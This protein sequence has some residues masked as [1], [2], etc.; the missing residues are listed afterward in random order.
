M[1]K[2]TSTTNHIGR[3]QFVNRLV[4]AWAIT[5]GLACS[6]QPPS[7]D[8]VREAE[9][10]IVNG[11][12]E[13]GWPGVGALV[14]SHT[15]DGYGSK[16]IFCTGT[17]IHPQWVLTAAHCLREPGF[18][19]PP[20]IIHFYVGQ[21]ART[22][23]V[24]LPAQ[25]EVLSVDAIFAHPAYASDEDADIALAHLA[26]PAA[27]VSYYSLNL[28]ST[29]VESGHP[30]LLY[31]GFGVDDGVAVTGQGIKRSTSMT[32]DWF[33]A[34]RYYSLYLGS[35]TCYGD[36][37]GPGLYGEEANGVIVGV[38]S[39]HYSNGGVDCQDGYVARTRVDTYHPWIEATL[40]QPIPSCSSDPSMCSCSAGCQ[41]DGTCDSTACA[42]LLCGEVLSCGAGCAAAPN[43]LVACYANGTPQARVLYQELFECGQVSCDGLGGAAWNAC[44]SSACSLELAACEADE[45][46][47]PPPDAG[48]PDA[49]SSPPD[50]A[51]A[52]DPDADHETPE[53][54]NDTHG[55]STGGGSSAPI[56]WLTMLGAW[57]TLLRRRGRNPAAQSTGS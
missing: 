19:P 20:Y 26:Q 7:D 1:K 40:A 52:T 11:S 57:V 14:F 43:C 24:G 44:I 4:V 39:K 32:I 50:D 42:T 35:G 12:L 25:G 10:A 55:C 36:S 5:Q 53:A 27:N 34:K 6:P 13:D 46:S 48:S 29:L 37:G 17:L 23:G 22:S 2:I 41:P 45:E 47:A 16:G 8:W 28:S 21:D 15:Y 31:V 9:Q 51:P 30:S 33:D 3:P 18:T 38:N 49:A 54:A 56:G